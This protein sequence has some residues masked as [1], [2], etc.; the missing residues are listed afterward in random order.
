[1]NVCANN[2]LHPTTQLLRSGLVAKRFWGL[3][4]AY[5]EKVSDWLI[6][7]DY[8]HDGLQRFKLVLKR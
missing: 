2:A 6:M 7:A 8:N 1:M 4:M 3:R 5:L